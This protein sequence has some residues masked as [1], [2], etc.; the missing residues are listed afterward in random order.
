MSYSTNYIDYDVNIITRAMIPKNIY[1]T[2]LD[3]DTDWGMIHRFTFDNSLEFYI[4]SNF[5]ITSIK[6]AIEHLKNDYEQFI[7]FDSPEE[8]QEYFHNDFGQYIKYK[9][10]IK[11]YNYYHDN[12]KL[13]R[14]IIYKDN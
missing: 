11:I 5:P 6:E 8:I 13:I 14:N 2:D 9:D 7:G 10:C 4:G 1:L 12:E 3:K